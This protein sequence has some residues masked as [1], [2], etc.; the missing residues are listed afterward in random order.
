MCH[1]YSQTFFCAHSTLA[2]AF[3]CPHGTLTNRHCPAPTPTETGGGTGTGGTLVVP[4]V[5]T[6]PAPV[7]APGEAR[8]ATV[9]DVVDDSQPCGAC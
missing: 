9:V 2:F 5:A 7:A 6:F 8:V 4:H 3:P 1:Y